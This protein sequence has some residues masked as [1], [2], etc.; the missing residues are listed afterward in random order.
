[1]STVD[2]SVVDRAKGDTVTTE[3]DDVKAL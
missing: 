1:L 3:V 2:N